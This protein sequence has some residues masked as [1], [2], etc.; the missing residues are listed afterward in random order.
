MSFG[1]LDCQYESLMTVDSVHKELDME[2][3]MRINQIR[4]EANMQARNLQRKF[5]AELTRLPNFT[6]TM[7]INQLVLKSNQ[8][9]EY[10]CPV[11]EVS[12]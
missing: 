4:I 8:T 3:D 2:M 6:R 5:N 12:K 11:D 9:G 10:R 7:T 1:H